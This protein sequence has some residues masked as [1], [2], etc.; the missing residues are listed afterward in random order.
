MMTYNPAIHHRRS[1]PNLTL[2]QWVVMPNHF[3][4]ILVLDDPIPEG[5][6]EASAANNLHQPD[7]LLAD[8]SPRHHL[9]REI[10]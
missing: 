1:F 10:E 5:T 8:A 7:Y 4:G 2:D 3:H 6:G 9:P